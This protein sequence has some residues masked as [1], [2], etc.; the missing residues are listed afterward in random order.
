MTH[1]N[2]STRDVNVLEKIKDPEF[3]PAAGVITDESLPRD[4]HVTDPADYGSLVQQERTIIAKIQALETESSS[5]SQSQNTNETA[6]QG[7]QQ[8]LAELDTLIS[9]FPNY[10][11]ARNNRAQIIRRLYGDAMLLETTTGLPLPLIEQP[12]ATEKKEAAVRALQDLETSISLLSP[13]ASSTAIS[14]QAARTLSMAY[15][16]RAAIYLR[17]SKL[18]SDRMLDTDESRP[19]ASWNRVQ[20]EQAASHDLAYGGR[21]G[22]Q[23]AKGLAV[24]VN[25]TAKLCGQIVREA[26][27]RGYGP[28]FDE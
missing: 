28:S 8:C 14:P 23:I 13:A 16:Q 18:L 21:Y 10:A 9:E 11:S 27:K 1:V 15:T 6:I 5:E 17:T 24:S 3:N 20:F 4:P 7:Y 19:E 25:P 12:D 22:N 26:M 2:L